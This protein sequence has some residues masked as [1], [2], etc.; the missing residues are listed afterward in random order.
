MRNPYLAV[1]RTIPQRLFSGCIPPLAVLASLGVILSGLD[2][3][4]MFPNHS[5]NYG[6]IAHTAFPVFVLAV[7]FKQLVLDARGRLLPNAPRIPLAVAGI[8]LAIYLV[9]MPLLAHAIRPAPLLSQM[10]VIWIVAAS[11]L[12]MSIQSS[13]LS[14]VLP[15]LF[16]YAAYFTGNDNPTLQMRIAVTVETPLIAGSL[17]ALSIAWMVLIARRL[18]RMSEQSPGYQPMGL[19][20]ADWKTSPG[21]T[22]GATQVWRDPAHAMWLVLWAPTQRR[23][24]Y[25]TQHGASDSLWNRCRRWRS[26]NQRQYGTWAP[27]LLLVGINLWWMRNSSPLP[28]GVPQWADLPLLMLFGLP[29]VVTLFN[30]AQ[31]WQYRSIDILKPMRREDFFREMGLCMAIDLFGSLFVGAALLA[32]LVAILGPG[33]LLAFYSRDMLLI[34][35]L[36]IGGMVCAFGWVVWFLRYRLMVVLVFVPGLLIPLIIAMPVTR[37]SLPTALLVAS[38]LVLT[39]LGLTYDA[40]RRWLLTDLG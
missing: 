37:A 28:E 19:R 2:G 39:G 5:F 30:Y 11:V 23:L 10:A 36:A 3:L 14:G 32:A 15:L 13:W 4:G 17:I 27:L 18:S 9:A 26:V 33:H 24:Q 38:S 20:Q 7:H 6:A 31:Q 8:M 40:Y 21:S 1:A 16:F 22:S 29:V 12:H 25:A 34:S 35:L